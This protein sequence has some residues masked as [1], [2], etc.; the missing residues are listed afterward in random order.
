MIDMVNVCDT[1]S[2]VFRYAWF[3]GRGTLPDNHFTYLFT[4][5][6]GQ[7][8]ELGQYYVNLPFTK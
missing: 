5:A 6:D 8:S 3:I 2:I 7:L 4:P 1:S